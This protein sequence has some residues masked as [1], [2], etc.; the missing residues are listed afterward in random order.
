MADE[1]FSDPLDRF[2]EF[3]PNCS[4]LL[5]KHLTL[6]VWNQLKDRKTSLGVDLS[7]CIRSGVTHTDCEIGVYAG[8]AESYAVFSPLFDPIIADC[9]PDFIAAG[10]QRRRT[11]EAASFRPANPDPDG[12]YIVSTRVRVVRNLRGYRLR[13]TS[14][15]DED[16]DI[17]RR[18]KLAFG[19]FPGELAGV[20]RPLADFAD[21]GRTQAADDHYFERGDRFEDAAGFNRHWPIGR[22]VFFNE[23]RSF[24]SWVNEEDHLRLISMQRNADISGVFARLCKAMEIID[25]SFAFQHSD[26]LGYGASCPSNLGT[27]LRA[28]FHMKLPLS[29]AS[30]PFREI[31]A[32]HGLAARGHAGERRPASR[33]IYDI[34]N[35]YRLGLS[36]IQYLQ[37]CVE[38]VRKLID[39]EKSFEAKAATAIHSRVPADR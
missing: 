38:G 24:F 4:S 33:E 8:D 6:P 23:A 5:K 39:L 7:D 21:S 35:R 10:P 14:T 22:G 13:A 19:D 28:S 3:P 26:R 36:E 18:A 17:E 12:R 31:C 30:D 27:G 25:R 32:H 11:L 37:D 1:P 9:H 29:G 34:S 16:R 15:A 2:P 20:Y